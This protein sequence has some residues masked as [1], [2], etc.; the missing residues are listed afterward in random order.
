ME[1]V[2]LSHTSFTLLSLL[3]IDVVVVVVLVGQIQK[4]RGIDATSHSFLNL[5]TLFLLLLL[6]L[7]FGY[8]RIE[9][10]MLTYATV[11]RIT[12]YRYVVVVACQDVCVVS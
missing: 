2:A 5:F 1:A 4:D 8:R 11:F 3:L 10:A 6:S 9:A 12:T 7:L